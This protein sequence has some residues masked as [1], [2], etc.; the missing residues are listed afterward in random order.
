MIESAVIFMAVLE[1]TFHLRLK[2]FF[3]NKIYIL[4]GIRIHFWD[5]TILFLP[6][7]YDFRRDTP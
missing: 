4:L 5:I 7:K 3:K 1:I 6:T 2:R